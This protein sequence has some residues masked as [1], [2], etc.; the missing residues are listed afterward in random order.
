MNAVYHRSS[1]IRDTIHNILWDKKIRV[2]GTMLLKNM[3]YWNDIL[4]RQ[5]SLRNINSVYALTKKWVEEV[6]EMLEKKKTIHLLSWRSYIDMPTVGN[7]TKWASSG[8]KWVNH[9]S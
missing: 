6:F 9:Y 8:I 3:R 4:E 1:L 2:T 7:G 5:D